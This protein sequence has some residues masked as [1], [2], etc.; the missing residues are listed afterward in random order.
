MRPVKERPR[1]LTAKIV[2]DLNVSAVFNNGETRIIDFKKI[3]DKIGID[4]KSPAAILRK[5][6]VFKKFVIDNGTLSWKSVEQEIPWKSSTRKM[7]F[8]IGADIL[9]R[10]SQ[11]SPTQATYR[12]KIS[13]VSYT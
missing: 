13:A 11:P 3:F 7:P 10:N 8:E 2:S 4:K 9:Y 12:L 6:E 1:I 5:P